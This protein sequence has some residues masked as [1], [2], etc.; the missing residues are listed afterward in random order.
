M[1]QQ[2]NKAGIPLDTVYLDFPYLKAGSNFIVDEAAFDNLQGLA[3]QIHDAKMK[4]VVVVDS[5]IVADVNDAFYKQGDTDKTFI[6]SKQYPNTDLNGNLV[7]Y[8]LGTKDQK[9]V[10]VDWFN[11][12][13]I[14][15]WSQGLSLISTKVPF[16]GLWLNLNEPIT[17]APG[18]IDIAPPKPPTPPTES[19]KSKHNK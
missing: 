6:K 7:N 5:S 12:K 8:R 4:L 16:D 14:D 2:Y 18:E 17:A 15:M 19:E 1:M 10:F 3:K 11:D 13:C 9:V